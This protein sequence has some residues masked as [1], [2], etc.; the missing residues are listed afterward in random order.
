MWE[1][2]QEIAFHILKQKLISQPIL[3]Y[4]DFSREFILTTDASNDGAGAVLSQEQ[5]GK[6]LPVAYASRS[7]NKPERNYSTIEKELAAIVW[8]IKHFR[9]YLYGRKFKILSDHKPLTWIMSV[10]DPGSRLRWRVQLEE[11]DYEIVYK[12]GVALLNVAALNDLVYSIEKYDE[13]PGI[14]YENKG[15]AVLYNIEWRTNV[16]VDLI[17]TDNETIALKQYVKNFDVLWQNTVIRNWTRFAHFG[18]DAK[19]LLNQL[20]KTEGLLK[21]ITGQETGGKRKKRGVF[22][23]IGDLS[24]ILF[25]TMDD[26]DAKYYKDQIKLFEQNSEEMN[27]LLKQQLSVI[28]LSLGAVNSTL[29]DVE[30]NENL[31]K[32]G[33]NRITKYMNSLKSET[34]EKNELV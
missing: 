29:A 3:Q 18:N 16:Y 23:F 14:Y 6:V 33:I 2:S 21:E 19:E 4:P 24:K 7:F 10:K 28:R 30:Y 25:G 31:M 34:N 1:E 20:T 12:S 22:N 27:T 8:G 26:D 32:E 11:Y 15:V 17:K 13:S 5:I 9:P